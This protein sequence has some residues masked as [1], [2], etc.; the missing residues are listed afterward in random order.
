MRSVRAALL[1]L[2]LHWTFLA[3]ANAA[4]C[5]PICF[6]PSPPQYPPKYTQISS[7]QL[8]ALIVDSV[9]P[10][11][12][13]PH[14][15]RSLIHEAYLPFIFAALPVGPVT[16][17]PAPSSTDVCSPPA[18]PPAITPS[19]HPITPFHLL[20]ILSSQ[21]AHDPRGRPN[22]M[23]SLR[24]SQTHMRHVTNC[25]QPSAYTTLLPAHVALF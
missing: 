19:H 4:Q 20:H 2:P 22:R 18:S 24:T 16:P 12:L 1:C 3:S 14:Q 21:A 17:C 11:Y 8:L 25:Y 13:I 7:C 23:R 9:Q 15:P 10:D 6:T 5:R